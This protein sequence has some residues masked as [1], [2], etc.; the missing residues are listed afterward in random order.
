MRE[1]FNK[2]LLLLIVSAISLLPLRFAQTAAAQ[3]ASPT[4]DTVAHHIGM[5][6]CESAKSP[7][8]ANGCDT[9]KGAASSM[10]D[11]CGDNCAG[12]QMLLTQGFD[13]F[14]ISASMFNPVQSQQL[15]DPIASAE[16]RPPIVIS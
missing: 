14:F 9:Y 16:H 15:P 6:G 1:K 2:F 3:A 13:F 4:S 11:C 8:A 10:D 7:H 5:A 12:A